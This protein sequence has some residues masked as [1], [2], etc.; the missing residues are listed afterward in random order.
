M[1]AS[2]IS[3]NKINNYTVD[4]IIPTYRSGEKL[5]ML[6]TKLYSQTVKPSRVIILHTEEFEGQ[7]Q[8]LPNISESNIVFFIIA[9]YLPFQIITPD[10]GRPGI[11]VSG[12]TIPPPA[13]IKTLV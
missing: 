11:P 4:V 10:F 7:E 8:P 2:N 9:S 5:N 13:W 6:L 3:D 1:E 12:D